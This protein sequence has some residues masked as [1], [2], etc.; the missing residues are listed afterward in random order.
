MMLRSNQL[1]G[2]RPPELGSLGK[3]AYMPLDS[4]Q[5]PGACPPELGSIGELTEFLL[6]YNWFS[7]TSPPQLGSLR[8]LTKRK[9]RRNLSGTSP[10]ELGSHCELTELPLD[11]NWPRHLA[12]TAGQPR[13][14]HEDETVQQSAL[15]RV[16]A[17]AVP[18]RGRRAPG[19][20]G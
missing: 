8:E 14:A 17:R 20:Q 6:G 4:T 1:S 5:L 11:D 9:L 10:P 16:A 18:P 2:A 13:E 19:P 3:L 15:W 7:G 12:A